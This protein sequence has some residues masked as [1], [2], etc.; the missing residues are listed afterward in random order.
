MA[1]E[2]PFAGHEL[3]SPTLSGE[4]AAQLLHDRYARS[5]PMKPLGSH[6]DQNFLV[7]APDGRFV[8][9][10][11]NPGFTRVGLEAQN[12]AMLHLASNSIDFRAPIPVPDVD[13]QLIGQTDDQG[14]TFDVRL[15][16]FIDGNPLSDFDYLAPVVLQAHGSLAARAARALTDFNHPGLDRVLQWD[17]RHASDVVAALVGH[18]Q[19]VALRDEVV[20]LTGQAQSELDKLSGELRMGVIHADVTDVNVVATVDSSGRPIPDGLI[21]FGD[22]LR[23]WIVSDVAVAAVSLTAHDFD[24]PLE[25][26]AEIVRGFH[27]EYPL[28]DPE[29]DALWPLVVARAAACCVSSE[30][31]AM[32]EPDNYYAEESRDSDWHIWASLR[33]ISWKAATAAL[34][35]ATAAQPSVGATTASASSQPSRQSFID[36]TVSADPPVLDLSVQSDSLTPG[37][38]QT[39]GEL[40]RAITGMLDSGHGFG[41]FNEG[42]LNPAGVSAVT[43]GAEIFAPAGTTINA[44]VDVHVVSVDADDDAM[45]LGAFDQWLRVS[46][47][48]ATAA[49]GTQ[50]QAGQ[51]LGALMSSPSSSSLPDHLLVQVVSDPDECPPRVCDRASGWLPVVRDPSSFIGFQVAAPSPDAARLLDRRDSVLATTQEHYY[52]QPPRIE[53]GWRHHLFDTDGRRYVD[54]VNNVAILGHS[55][56]AV[57]QAVGR[58]LRLLNTNSRFHY[59]AMVAFSERLVD[60]LPESLDTVFLVSTGSEANEVAL[61]LVRAA[62]GAKDLVAVRSAYHGWT[63]ATDEVSTSIADNPGAA[64]DRPEW[65]HTVESPHTYRGRFRGADA[66]DRYADEA[67]QQLKDLQAKGRAIAG[68]IA[69]PVYGNAGGVLLPHGYLQQVYQAV[70]DVGGLCIA[71]EVQVGYGRLGEYFWGFEQQG[72]IPDVVTMAKCTGNGVPVGAVVTTSAIAAAMEEQG[73]FFSS[74]GGSPVGAVAA[75]AVLDTLETEQLQA[76]ARDVGS[77]LKKRLLE[78]TDKHPLVGTVHGMGLYLGVELVRDRETLEPA[79]D[80]ALAICERLLDLGIIVQP[81]SDHMNVLKVKPPLCLDL[82]SADQF[83]D[84]LDR[85]LTAGW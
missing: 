77:H 35:E 36:Q 38:W 85:V 20:R 53:R 50:V 52:V 40:R 14:R 58:Q 66:G 39:A 28:T 80:E 32:L 17:C 79:A 73:S 64:A 23:T 74:M 57:E 31:Q 6:Q 5:G 27:R 7:D 22:M 10:I 68:F 62:T 42:R 71:D 33:S 9:K 15:V 1:L 78:L 45:V 82:A 63:T 2:N 55:H 70:R 24:R 4:T 59:E 26:T 13:G 51:P 81:T 25:I 76:N 29:I 8:L 69:E 61:R 41:R 19:D 46:G 11:S 37:S 60:L 34:H 44:P 21:D 30:Q 67:K 18:V 83:V 54:M 65:I 16:T 72:V 48:R 84:A 3:L 47:L 75:L 49:A 56:P 12:A 43:T